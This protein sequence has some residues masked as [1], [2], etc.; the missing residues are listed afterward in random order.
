MSEPFRLPQGGRIDRSRPVRF[1]FDGRAYSGYAGDTL[2]SALLANG[3]RLVGR[4]FKYHRPR[5]ILTAGAEE[6]NPLVELRSGVR[7]ESNTRAT[8]AELYDGLEAASQNRW[9]SLSFD[10]SAINGAV[11][12]FISAGF[13]YKTFMW[14]ASFWEKVYEPIIRRAAG[15]GTASRLPDPDAYEAM[16][17]HCDVA[18][19]GSGAA[20]LA[21]AR[22]AGEAGARVLLLEQDFELGGGL[23]LAPAWDA[24]RATQIDALAAMPEVRVLPRTT[25]VGYYDGNVL[26]AVERVSDH[27][28]APAAGD[29]RQR[30]WTIRARQVV[31]AT[32][33]IEQL[34]AFPDNDRPGVM[35][36][37]AALA[38]VRRYG[39]A[40][41]WR[42][43]VFATN[44]DAYETAFAL[45]SAGVAVAAIID[46]RASSAAAVTA[47]SQGIEVRLES[48]IVGVNGGRSLN[49]VRVRGRSGGV[50]TIDA[51]LICVSG[52]WAPNAHLAS[53]TRSKLVWDGSLNTF[54]PGPPLQQERSAGAARGRFGLAEAAR[55]GAS[56]GHAAALAVQVEK[57][58]ASA[59]APTLPDAERE[60]AITPQ[61]PLHIVEAPGKAFVDLQ[62]DVTV[63]DIRQAHREGYVHV[64][65][66]KRY[67]THTMATDQGKSGGL[68]GAAVLAKARGEP[69]QAI[70]IPTYR[71]YV[72]PV[73]WGAFGGRDVHHHFVP[74][75]RTPLHAW[76]SA[77][78]GVFQETGPWLRAYY[79]SATRETGWEPILR[80]ARAV[81]SG[82][83]LCDVSTLGKIDL[84]GADA[85]QFLDRMYVNTFS[86][87]RVGRARYGLMLREDGIVFDDGTV[88]RLGENH[89]VITTTTAKAAEVLEHMEFYHQ[90]V[91]PSLDLQMCSVTDHWAQIAIAGPK[92]RDTLAR[93]VE[94]L[95]L[96]G[97]AFPFMAA[98]QGRI[99]DVP[100]RVF[101]VSFSGELAYEVAVPAGHSE[102]VWKVLYEAGK[103][104]G[105]V[106]YGVEAMGLMRVEK[107]HV[108][109]PEINGQ[110][111]AGDLGLA[112]LCKKTGDFV[113]RV[114]GMRPGLTDPSRETIVG[115]RA[116]DPAF[117]KR[118][119]GGAHLVTSPG[120]TES[121]GYVTS[122]TRS[123]VLDNWIGL[124]MLRRAQERTG[125]RMWAVFPLKSEAVEVEIT[126]PHHVDPENTRVLA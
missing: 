67:T 27:L 101:R 70:G 77:N 116:V 89:F 34:A 91:W 48:E 30:F 122:V 107:G 38:Y 55:D 92:S 11:S 118:L 51:D 18:V 80:E 95:A 69:V 33:A 106:P 99:A 56:A 32:G 65:H 72:T 102:R 36:A 17:W 15:L 90:T 94:G 78:G 110:T 59:L 108:A 74:I 29:V 104:D 86:T 98:G 97:Q 5:G 85:A 103:A 75:R 114:N 25:V 22:A 13:Y 119:R 3:V 68:L 126:S 46:V 117:E 43:V 8:V 123:V 19:V 125:T 47:R 84:Q 45:A 12:R 88:S 83:G 124:A 100:V 113:G 73:T 54:V 24:W 20:G 58:V 49:G 63:D 26:G 14:P 121:Q 61:A 42:A 57:G 10:V 31:L 4:S 64:E 105:I 79:Y 2:A 82:V 93:C 87:L 41:G 111:T 66:A 109:G 9:P 71:P 50:S 112:R 40:P 62:N 21:A 120:A 28:A 44:D 115:V 23:L 52:G 76:H 7:R 81:R 39:V 37:G 16:H 96:D 53:Q 1:T 35:L 6:P 60:A